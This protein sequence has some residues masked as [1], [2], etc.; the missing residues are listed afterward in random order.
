MAEFSF[1]T[2]PAYFRHAGVRNIKYWP[3]PGLP[4]G[5]NMGNSWSVFRLGDVY[6]MRGEAEYWTGDL[7]HAL[8]DFNTVRE[9]AYSG[10]TAHDWTLADLTPDNILQERGREM[11]WE[12]VRRIDQIRMQVYTGTPYFTRARSYP[13]KPADADNH[14]F[15]LPVPIVEINTNPNLKQN[16][17]Y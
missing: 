7:A 8:I 16:P 12:D 3:Q 9:R 1:G 6:L 5:N 17:G 14:T 2:S 4:P 11:A 10:S 15:L 13:P